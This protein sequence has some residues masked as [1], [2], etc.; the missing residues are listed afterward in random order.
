V[1]QA[2]RDQVASF[3]IR[4]RQ[5]E[6]QY[7]RTTITDEQRQEFA[8][9]VESTIRQIES[10]YFLLHTRNGFPTAIATQ[11]ALH[12]HPARERM[13]IK[14]GNHCPDLV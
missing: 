8:Q 11:P 5:A 1:R 10:G 9:L 14:T 6:V 2:S 13:R 12:G 7:L 3:I 4:K